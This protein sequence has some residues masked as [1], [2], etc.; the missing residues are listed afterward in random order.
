[1]KKLIQ[2]LNNG[3][4]ELLE[5]PIPMPREGCLLIKSD[6]SLVSLGTEN[7]LVEFG[8]ANLIKKAKLQPD[9]VKKPLKKLIMMD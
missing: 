7:M 3:K 9:K 2:N 5:I 4:T 6:F 1:M 8:K